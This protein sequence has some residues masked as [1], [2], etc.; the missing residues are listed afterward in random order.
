MSLKIKT[1]YY[2]STAACNFLLYGYHTVF[3]HWQKTKI[4]SSSS[5]S[6]VVVV[7]VVVVITCDRQ[8]RA[9]NMSKNTKQ[10]NVMVVSR[11]VILSSASWNQR[12]TTHKPLKHVH[13]T[14]C[15]K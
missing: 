6:K 8:L 4:S 14:L 3:K 7:V 11:R 10:V 13:Q 12:I 15:S 9:L 1:P 5:S 2:Y